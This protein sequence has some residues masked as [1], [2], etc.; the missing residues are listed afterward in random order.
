MPEYHYRAKKGPTE[1]VEGNME[2]GSVDE[3]VEKLDQMGLLAIHLDEAKQ[4]LQRPADSGQRVKDKAAKAPAVERKRESS[5]PEK[6]TFFGRVKST[7]ITLFGRQLS[8]L[9][10]SGVP[11]LRALWIIQEQTQNPLFKKFLVRA[12]EEINNGRSLSAVLA[13][14]P[15]FF[16]PL[17]V[18]MVHM[19]EDSGNLQEAMLRISDYRQRQ[20]EILSRV[21]TAMA[22]PILMGLTGMGTIIFMLTFVIPKLTTLFSSLG[23]SLPLPTKILMRI[24]GVF[25]T[26]ELWVGAAVLAILLVTLVRWRASQMRWLW[27]VASLRIPVIKGFVMKSEL[28][29]FSRTFELLIKSGL[30]ILRAI[31]VAVPVLGNRVYRHQLEKA[32]EDLTGGGSLGKSLRECG[33]FPLFMT[34]LI[35]VSEESGKL[36]E[37]MQE[38]ASFYERETDEQI[39]IMTSLMEPLM[40]LVM[41]VIVGFIVMAMLLP[42]FELNMIVK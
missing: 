6:K 24:S 18:A 11:I 8:S 34:N 12:Q 21:R 32:K 5:L 36:D 15:K 7:E 20:E 31:E 30:P 19:G 29:R 27:S 33:V 10:K 16:S 3:A 38:M 40:I 23:T 14:Y 9:V 42:M 41:G 28:A 22:Y 39:K 17:Y 25:Q 35:S 26:P 2:A 37:A 1:V 4:S 13:G